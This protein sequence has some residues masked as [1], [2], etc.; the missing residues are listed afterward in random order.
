LTK[1]ELVNG[2][3]KEVG[4]AVARHDVECVL[5]ALSS[6]VSRTLHETGSVSLPGIVKISLEDRSARTYRDP[7]NPDRII[8]VEARSVLKA[9][10]SAKLRA[11][12]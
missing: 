11:T 12:E 4:N 10:V 8:D 1:R 3:I 2:I 7:R 9:R 6:V 5:H